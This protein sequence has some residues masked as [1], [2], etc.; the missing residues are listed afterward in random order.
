MHI[1]I[2]MVENLYSNR[3]KYLINQIE[4]NNKITLIKIFTQIKIQM[5]KGFCSNHKKYH[6]K[7]LLNY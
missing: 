5:V 7:K 6:T 4:Q 1:K 3:K 2:R